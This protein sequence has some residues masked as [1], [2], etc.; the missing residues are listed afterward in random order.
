MLLK[1]GIAAQTC[2]NVHDL[3]CVYPP[4]RALFFLKRSLFLFQNS[5]YFAQEACQRG[6][7]LFEQV[8]YNI[9]HALVAISHM[10][11]YLI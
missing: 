11:L 10:R 6:L 5:L 4:K 9:S 2:S 1:Q 8:V 3:C 7:E